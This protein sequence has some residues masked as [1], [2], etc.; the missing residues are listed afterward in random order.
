[1]TQEERVV[2]AVDV[3]SS[4]TRIAVGRLDEKG[5]VQL[6]SFSQAAT[7]GVK[8][9]GVED[10]AALTK[11]INQAAY[12]LDL[13]GVAIDEVYV[14]ISGANFRVIEVA[15]EHEVEEESVVSLADW[16]VLLEKSWAF[17]VSEGECIYHVEPQEFEL[18]GKPEFDLV[19][20]QGTKLRMI[21]KLLVGMKSYGRDVCA[22]VSKSCLRV[23][24][25]VCD[26]ISSAEG[27]L[28]VEDK[29]AG[30]ALL[31]AG[32]DLMKLSLYKDGVLRYV[33]TIP[34][35]GNILTRDLRT[36][37]EISLLQAEE[38]KKKHVNVFPLKKSNE[39]IVLPALETVEAK[40]F[41]EGDLTDIVGERLKEIV[42]KVKMAIEESGYQGE[43]AKGMVLIG[44]TA[45]LKG[46]ASFLKFHLAM[47][48]Q[49]GVPRMSAGSYS[50]LADPSSASVWGLLALGV[51]ELQ[52]GF[53]PYQRIQKIAEVRASKKKSNE[54]LK[55][56]HSEIFKQFSELG[57]AIWKPVK[58][59]LVKLKDEPARL[60]RAVQPKTYA[61]FNAD[62]SEK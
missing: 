37:C 3:G 26:Y 59:K 49:I 10:V 13:G 2:A 54:E 4:K 46:I 53:S 33:K 62:L 41:E 48:V 56:G 39:R 23:D 12:A 28:S 1:M 47:D 52:D 18:D 20:K 31:D 22:A 36:V 34:F 7:A 40:A 58:Q 42:A 51:R 29:T 15:V 21:C 44:G 50:E 17:K 60:I 8:R 57:E 32:A 27:V 9:G 14:N 55:V 61:F 43:L 6:L 16:N 45:K 24:Q 35:A 5:K 25:A 30:V 11:S 38:L 19:G